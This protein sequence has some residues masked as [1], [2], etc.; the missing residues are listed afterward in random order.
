M[1][2]LVVS[3]ALA[4]LGVAALLLLWSEGLL[5][6]TK[7]VVIATVFICVAI[8]LRAVCMSH[9]TADYW[10]FLRVWIDEIRTG[11]F[12]NALREGLSY[13]NYNF[14]YLFFLGAVS[15]SSLYSLYLIK[16]FSVVF[17]VLLAWS[18]MRLTGLYTKSPN[19]RLA[20]F[21]LTL[22][23]PT[24][25]LNG[26]FWGQCDVIYA[27]LAVLSLY[28]ALKGRPWLAMVFAALAFAFKLQ[29]IF[30]LPI[31]ALF[32]FTKRMKIRH[33]LAFPATYVVTIL[34]AVLVGRPFFDA[35]TIYSGQVDSIGS[36]LNYNSPSLFSIVTFNGVL[37]DFNA[38]ITAAAIGIAF[39][40]LFG[41]LLLLFFKRKQITDL[42]ILI[43]A[44][45]FVI[46]IPFFLPRMHDRYFFLADVVSLALALALPK[47][48]PV[49]VFCSVASLLAYIGYLSGHYLILFG[50]PVYMVWG[51]I[52][53]I[54]AM[55]FCF[56]ALKGHLG[57]RAD[58]VLE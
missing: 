8:G 22:L 56:V 17:D 21:L 28:L 48:L 54:L 39:F 1:D 23:L 30:L 52:L 19:R 50:Q 14:L 38:E 29:A 57:R 7:H 45:L 10:Q 18:V 58:G 2:D 9:V 40:F 41:L 43:T 16:L 32:L 53:L 27:A 35:L 34:P 11:G 49:P 26:S 36:R 51:G 42:V 44:A 12:A 13:Y 31:F 55:V 15:S 33:L 5:R 25:I 47:Y 46:G 3:I 6:E 24:V 20:A 4:A 37:K